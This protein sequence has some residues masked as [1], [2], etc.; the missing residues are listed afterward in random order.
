MGGEEVA[1]RA[2]AKEEGGSESGEEGSEGL[3]VRRWK[4][5][6]GWVGVGR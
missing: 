6:E 1:G 5:G 2:G 4:G 3:R